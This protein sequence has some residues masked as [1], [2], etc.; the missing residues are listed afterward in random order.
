[1]AASK[2][3]KQYFED[4]LGVERRKSHL[5]RPGNAAIVMENLEMLENQSLAARQGKK[6]TGQ[7]L[8]IKQIHQYSY[9]DDDGVTHEELIGVG[10]H[11]QG[12]TKHY[13]GDLFKLVTS[14]TLD[15][16]RTGGNTSWDY[17]ML[18]DT[19]TNTFKFRII[20]NGS[21]VYSVD[22]GDGLTDTGTTLKTLADAIDAL[23]NFSCSCPKTAVVNGNQSIN[24][25]TT[26]LTVDTGHTLSVGDWVYIID[27]ATGEKTW[28]EVMVAGATAIT[29]HAI[30]AVM[31]DFSDNQ[32]IGLGALRVAGLVDLHYPVENTNDTKSVTLSYWQMVP[33][34]YHA[35][36]AI[37][38][39][40]PFNALLLDATTPNINQL[41]PSIENHR[42]C[43]Y[44]TAAWI[45][46][47]TG[48]D[49]VLPAGSSASGLPV[50]E[51]SGVWKYD[52]HSF[53]LSGIP[54]KIDYSSDNFGG[55]QTAGLPG[56]G[57]LTGNYK[58]KTSLVFIDAQ[59]NETEV[60]FESY[61]AISSLSADS[62]PLTFYQPVYS[63][64][65]LALNWLA[66]RGATTSTTGSA[67]TTFTVP[68][69]HT[70]RTGQR[71]YIPDN[72]TGV[73]TVTTATVVS[74]TNTS[75]TLDKTI[76][77]P[78]SPCPNICNF[79]VR[80]WRTKANGLDFFL[81]KELVV[82]PVSSTGNPYTDNNADSTLGFSL[83]GYGPEFIQTSL[84]KG[85]ALAAHQDCLVVG[86]GGRLAKKIAWEDP[87][88][89]E[90]TDKAVRQENVSFKRS[91]DISCIKGDVG[92]SLVV[93]GKSSEFAFRGSLA[94]ADYEVEKLTDKGK[95][96]SSPYG[97]TEGE[98]FLYG[99]GKQGTLKLFDGLPDRNFGNSQL[100]L[101]LKNPFAEDTMLIFEHAQVFYDDLRHRIHMYL[102]AFTDAITPNL[103]HQY[104][105]YD[106][107]NNIWYDFKDSD[108]RMLPS[109]GFAIVDNQF[110]HQAWTYDDNPPT[111][112]L[113]KRLDNETSV[114]AEDYY[115]NCVSYDWELEPQWD[116]GGY[117]QVNKTWQELAIYMLQPD[118]F[119]AAFDILVRTYRNWVN[120]P[121]TPNR[122]L[123]YTAST[124]TEDK[125]KLNSNTKAKRHKFN[126]SG[127]VAKNPPII[128]GYEYTV[129][130]D[131]YSPDRMA[132]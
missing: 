29:F 18:A 42:N 96:V 108:E 6:V 33:S 80:L 97:L 61:L 32:V 87:A 106:E 85:N 37:N 24:L 55:V 52:G 15:I 43:I 114:L 101:F 44:I 40:P 79:K 70:L 81:V 94:D 2:D 62:I 5:T 84:P 126:F 121:I 58:W 11:N 41:A 20:Q 98:E 63:T 71:V 23:A 27:S 10:G 113:F 91:A 13:S 9:V 46:E 82:D 69:R 90:S 75:V 115:D 93:F 30:G 77:V 92:S 100:P 123:S 1:M 26:T 130:G 89:P 132:E 50:N 25:S 109:G 57:V 53:G 128:T 36:A 59:N 131:C 74:Y 22:V 127:T 48:T 45:K 4:F 47:L 19:A 66:V 54:K 28:F 7:P 119:A 21:V 105:V 17:S 72:S 102:P 73:Y 120:T 86:G 104:L 125:C 51:T 110:Y 116:D 8:F 34:V 112:F 122:T 56:A 31:C 83:N 67:T 95:G 65:S 111:G 88:W 35:N 12:A 103:S 118:Y 68:S 76:N 49:Y 60:F 14:V 16:T 124:S 107:K 78:A 117:P 39:S 3:F 38:S 99:V 64:A 129:L